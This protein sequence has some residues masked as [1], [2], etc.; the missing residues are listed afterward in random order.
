MALDLKKLLLPVSAF[1]A[2]LLC[3][4]DI[5]HAQ[6]DDNPLRVFRKANREGTPERMDPEV[7][8]RSYVRSELA[9]KMTEST[10]ILDLFDDVSVLAQRNVTREAWE[11][12]NSWVGKV[13][14]EPESEVTLVERDGVIAGTVR[15]G[16]R[17]FKIRHAGDDLHAI[18]E[19]DAGKYSQCAT[20]DAQHI[21]SAGGDLPGNVSPSAPSADLPGGLPTVD[22]LVVYTPEARTAAGGQSSILATIDLA[23]LETNQAYANSGINY[24]VELVKAVEVAYTEVTSFSAMLGA[25]RNPTDGVL[26][27][28]HDLRDMYGADMVSMI[29]GGSQY[30]GL[31]Y[32]M[33]NP[34]P[35]F[36]SWA[37]SV[38]ARGCATGFYSFAHEL[39]HN[40]GCAHDRDQAGTGAYPWSFGH[41]ASDSSWRTIMA[42]APGSRVKHFSNPDVMYAGE[43]TGVSN[44]SAGSADNAM[45]MNAT[46]PIVAD[47][48]D[49]SVYSF[50]DSKMTSEGLL[51]ALSWEGRPGVEEN[52]F[53]LQLAS[54]IPRSFG[55]LLRGAVYAP[56]PFHGGVLYFSNPFQRL[57][58]VQMDLQGRATSPVDL[59]SASPGMT[60]YYQ[61]IFRDPAQ[62]DE[63]GIGLT[64][65][66][67]VT[68]VP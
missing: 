27:E 51:P 15:L 47:F 34:G 17:T 62:L 5:A 68:Y 29:V 38:V 65:P 30:C 63:T 46:L 4:A 58:P 36:E 31:G 37:F 14:N 20:S 40:L 52:D 64:N 23:V 3:T 55:I 13:P 21:V 43:P 9:Q 45:T 16:Q 11:K 10:I 26:D 59:S 61:I 1:A 57:G 7:L 60:D 39:G 19:I 42:Y 6:R 67:K 25:L 50:G 18:E 33:A 54:A 56:H 22:V 41:R 2:S 49:A 12:T 35:Y 44:S 32:M 28:V 8:R 66:V 48:R 53:K 24:R